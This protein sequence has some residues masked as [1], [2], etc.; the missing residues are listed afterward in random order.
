MVIFGQFCQNRASRR[1]YKASENLK[2]RDTALFAIFA[3]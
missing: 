2:S 3:L 1:P